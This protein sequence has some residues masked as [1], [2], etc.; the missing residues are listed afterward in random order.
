MMNNDGQFLPARKVWE[1]YG[2]TS[3]TL[4]RWIADNRLNFPAPHYFGRLRF[5]RLSDLEAWETT[6][7]TIERPLRGMQKP[8][9]ERAE[10]PDTDVKCLYIVT[11]PTGSRS[12]AFRYRAGG[13]TIKYTIG[14]ANRHSQHKRAVPIVS[15]REARLVATALNELVDRFSANQRLALNA[16]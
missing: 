4:Y 11:Q 14:V 12:Y 1:R 16:S 7:R 2:V 8:P 10:E 13:Q 3:M 15:L 9:K 6:H 5:W